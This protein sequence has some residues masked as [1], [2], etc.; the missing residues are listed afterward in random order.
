MFTILQ[1][2]LR[3][4]HDLSGKKMHFIQQ[5]QLSTKS[6]QKIEWS[7]PSFVCLSLNLSGPKDEMSELLCILK[8]S[9]EVLYN[10]NLEQCIDLHINYFSDAN[11]I[12]TG[13]K[14]HFS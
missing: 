6:I 14:M 13:Q 8:H 3:G 10:M 12:F 4:Q 7:L 11:L 9:W 2:F 1:I 5:N